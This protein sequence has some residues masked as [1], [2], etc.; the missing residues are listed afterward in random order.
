MNGGD[1]IRVGFSQIFERRYHNLKKVKVF[2]KTKTVL[3]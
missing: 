2:R 1:D 3:P